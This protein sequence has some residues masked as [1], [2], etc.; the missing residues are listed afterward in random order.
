M[1]LGT[2]SSICK[3]KSLEK[4]RGAGGEGKVPMLPLNNFSDF[5]PK[6]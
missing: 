6:K 4:K 1:N 3:L 5:F 2:V